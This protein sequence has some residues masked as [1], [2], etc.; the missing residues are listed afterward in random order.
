M[1][2]YSFCGTAA[3]DS[4]YTFLTHLSRCNFALGDGHVEAMGPH[5][6]AERWLKNAG[7]WKFVVNGSEILTVTSKEDTGTTW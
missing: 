7:N 1:S 5:Q 4:S 3:L 6:V 2:D